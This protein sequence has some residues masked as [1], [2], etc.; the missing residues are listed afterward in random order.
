[1]AGG[2]AVPQAA[3]NRI[4]EPRPAN[5]TD[6][7]IAIPPG[8]VGRA[9]LSRESSRAAHSC[10]PLHMLRRA[11][12]R[13]GENWVYRNERL[14]TTHAGRQTAHP[15]GSVSGADLHVRV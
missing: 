13:K 8:L 10:Q 4:S 6:L 12:R 5:A 14:H 11:L 1:M 2:P 7:F 15:R 3:S 9:C